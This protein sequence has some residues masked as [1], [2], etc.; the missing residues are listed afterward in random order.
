MEAPAPA[1]AALG[2]L[3]QLSAIHSAGISE[4]VTPLS[5][6][7]FCV[8]SKKQPRA[9]PLGEASQH[10]SDCHYPVS[11]AGDHSLVGKRGG[12]DEN[13]FFLYTRTQPSESELSWLSSLK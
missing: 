1:V 4:F 6:R 3:A 10:L 5:Q 11:S 2:S 12:G 8:G 13:L 7:Q 9:C